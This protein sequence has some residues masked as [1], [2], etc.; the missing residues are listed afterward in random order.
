MV[1]VAAA[2]AVG[3][4]LTLS[5]SKGCSGIGF[6]M[7]SERVFTS[8]DVRACPCQLEQ[9]SAIGKLSIGTDATFF[10]I[11]IDSKY[12]GAFRALP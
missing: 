2:R 1:P 3:M 12:R 6:D 5:I 7:R 9:H 4:G 8:T 11:A 10:G